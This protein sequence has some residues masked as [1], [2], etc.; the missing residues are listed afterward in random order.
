M[1]DQSTK[2]RVTRIV[3]QTSF[4][5][6]A[7]GAALSPI[8]F[9]DEI[10]LVPVYGIM[11]SRIGKAH[12]LGITEV[13]WRPIFGAITAGLATRAALSVVVAMIPGVAAVAT[14]VSATVLTRQLASHVSKACRAEL[15]APV[16]GA[17]T[18]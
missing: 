13:P 9:A 18:A 1:S 4:L 2:A 7:L 6:A 12:G 3:W 17:A 10:V 16:S 5:S 11:A 14:A 8:P 15:G